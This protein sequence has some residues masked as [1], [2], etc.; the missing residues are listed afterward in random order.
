MNMATL[1]P[2]TDLSSEDRIKAFIEEIEKEPRKTVSRLP[3]P[4]FNRLSDEKKRLIIILE[5]I[6]FRLNVNFGRELGDMIGINQPS[7]KNYLRGHYASIDRFH[8]GTL[9]RIARA[10]GISEA[11]LRAYL[12]GEEPPTHQALE[13]SPAGIVRALDQISTHEII[14]DILPYIFE[15]ILKDV[16]SVS[17]D[18]NLLESDS[19]DEEEEEE[20]MPHPGNL[21]L[22]Q[23]LEQRREEL[24]LTDEKLFRNWLAASFLPTEDQ[25]AVD[26]VEEMFELLESDSPLPNK[27]LTGPLRLILDKESEELIR[28]RDGESPKGGK[29]R[30]NLKQK[31]GVS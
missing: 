9:A 5:Q 24:R 4:A 25:S 21:R 20:P 29:S 22:K 7:I 27:F 3:K 17:G 26:Q 19:D 18:N 13:V 11:M 31:K 1:E 30:A 16:G 28:I 6:A 23:L 10:R 14:N 15:K 2:E 8:P 12:K